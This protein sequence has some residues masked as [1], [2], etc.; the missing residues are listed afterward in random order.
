MASKP[1]PPKEERKTMTRKI[2]YALVL[3]MAAWAATGT[4]AATVNLEKDFK[5]LDAAIARRAQYIQQRQDNMEKLRIMPGNCTT[6][7]ALYD[8]NQRLFD[9]YLKYSSDSALVYAQRCI[10]I[11]RQGDMPERLVMARADRA[12]ALVLRGKG[13][14]ATDSMNVLGQPWQYS[15]QVR[16]RLAVLHL[17]Y[18]MRYVMRRKADGSID[19]SALAY[20]HWKPYVDCLPQ[21]QWQALYYTALFTCD[22][23]LIPRLEQQLE[24]ADKPSDQAAMLALALA[25]CWEKA[26]QA[27]TACHY[28]VR[29]ATYDVQCATHDASSLLYVLTQPFLDKAS[30]RA[31]VYARVCSENINTYHDTGRSLLMVGIHS[32]IAEGYEQKMETT[33]GL[34]LAVIVLLAGAVVLAAGMVWVVR[35]RDR[36]QVRM[37]L[38]MRGMNDRLRNM[39]DNEKAMQ[40][41]LRKGNERL[42]EELKTRNRNFM[43]VYRLV[44]EYINDV[45]AF[46][47]SVFN[48]I[49]A[50]RVD[51]ARRE[52]ASGG[53][54]EQY[55]SGFYHHFDVAFLSSHPDF[56]DRINALMRPECQLALPA[57]D[58]LTPELR[59]YALV[60]IGIVDVPS[61]S[62]FLHYSAQTIYNYRLRIRRGARLEGRAFADAVKD[63]YKDFC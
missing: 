41:Q 60:S 49:T 19:R 36:R 2:V 53:N 45:R 61:I 29:S 14:Q 46:N 17:E 22:R 7:A 43:D 44:S 6:Y 37:L 33:N 54:T 32:A 62:V 5:Q 8:Y 18:S 13:P 26:G 24:Q 35:K 50:G 20:R 28:L 34:L 40:E 57:P 1:M 48:M 55:L 27:E 10:A 9:E 23:R 47:K 38:T 15:G 56:L 59:I 3:A 52:L 51:K 31:A 4:R 42:Q 39:V 11:A 63:M 58:S 25:R 21:G 12:L 16:Q 30:R